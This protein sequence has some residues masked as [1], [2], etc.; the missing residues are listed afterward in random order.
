[1]L[2]TGC[3]EVRKNR[4][5][6][7]SKAVTVLRQDL[8]F[9]AEQALHFVGIRRGTHDGNFHPVQRLR[10]LYRVFQEAPIQSSHGLGRE[11]FAEPGLDHPRP[12]SFCHNDQGAALVGKTRG[13]LVAGFHGQS[14]CQ[15]YAA[16]AALVFRRWK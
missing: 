13:V 9:V 8:H 2:P 7:C 5:Q 1:V 11:A 4:D 6:P 10:E 16:P 3:G 15:S 14:M 12:W